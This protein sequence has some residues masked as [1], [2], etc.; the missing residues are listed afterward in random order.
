MRRGSE[1]SLDAAAPDVAALHDRAL[2]VPNLHV[3]LVVAG[4]AALAAIRA[5]D[6]SAGFDWSDRMIA[7][8][9]A[10][11]LTDAPVALELRGT[12][13]A[14]SGEPRDA[15]RLY[16]AARSHAL[17]NGLRWPAVPATT[18]LLDRATAALSPADA[19]AARA[20]GTGLT[21][22]D[23]RTPTGARDR[24]GGTPARRAR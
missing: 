3:A 11:G 7:H 22:A 19:E 9:L 21:L 14:L 1:Q 20:E 24:A 23:V 17:R 5:G 18:A 16:A 10:F 15:V 12:L 8:R 6:L 13:L 2:A 4:T